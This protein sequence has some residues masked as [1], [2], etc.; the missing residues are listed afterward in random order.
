MSHTAS[1]SRS[2]ELHQRGGSPALSCLRIASQ[3]GGGGA[4]RRLRVLDLP[5]SAVE[6]AL[7]GDAPQL[8]P[9]GLPPDRWAL[10]ARSPLAR[11][12][13]M[14]G[15]V[16]RSHQRLAGSPC[17]MHMLETAAQREHVTAK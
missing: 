16:W 8:A 1:I 2:P 6:W 12:R 9:Q 11:E 5:F 15:S 13:S 4:P 14:T 3:V 10:F 17:L 7:P